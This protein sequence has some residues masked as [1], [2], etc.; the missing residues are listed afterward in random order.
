MLRISSTSLTARIFFPVFSHMTTYSHGNA[1]RI[2]LVCNDECFNRGD[3][4]PKEA[5]PQEQ[6]ILWIQF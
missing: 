4:S 2:P 3:G 5:A 1:L 6:A